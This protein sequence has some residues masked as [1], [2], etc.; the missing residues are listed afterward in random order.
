LLFNQL[1]AFYESVGWESYTKEHRL[2]E[3]QKAVRNSAYVVSTWSGD[4]LIS[5]VGGLSYDSSILYLQDDLVTPIQV[6]YVDTTFSH[7]E[8]EISHHNR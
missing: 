7:V 2:P 3:W 6:D 8:Q 5:L 4:T 1:L